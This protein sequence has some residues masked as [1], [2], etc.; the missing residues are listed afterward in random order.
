MDTF[1]GEE[2]QC[3]RHGYSARDNGFRFDIEVGTSERRMSEEKIKIAA[4]V[5]S[6]LEKE[7]NSRE[8]VEKIITLGESDN[9]VADTEVISHPDDENRV[10][11][12][13]ES[14]VKEDGK[15]ITNDSQ[16]IGIPQR[17]EKGDGGGEDPRSP[18]LNLPPSQS[19]VPSSPP[20]STPTVT[21]IPTHPPSQI[22]SL[23]PAPTP[24]VT[25]IIIPI[26][27]HPHAGDPLLV[28]D[29]GKDKLRGIA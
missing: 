23:P 4:I 5:Q 3:G 22:P 24:A 29:P 26:P 10:E 9:S 19:Q 7:K 15:V 12:L 1:L 8:N 11:E 6:S 17:A 18:T 25:P 20:S 27:T 21:P 2:L 16:E 14:I 28:E 13:S